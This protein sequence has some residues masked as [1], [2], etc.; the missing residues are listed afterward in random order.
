MSDAVSDARA[1]ITLSPELTN[2]LRERLTALGDD[3][4]ILGHRDSE[5]TGHA[6]ILEEDI[7][8]ANVAQDEI[9]HAVLWYGLVEQLGGPDP[10]RL[11]FFRSEGEFRSAPFVDRPRGDWA[12]TMARQFLFDAHEAELLPRLERSAFEPMAEV[13]A[14][15]R[16]EELFHLRHSA[17]WL[18][19]LAHGT[20]ES[21]RRLEAALD[22]LLP[23]LPGLLEPLPGDAA[24]AAAGIYPDPAELEAAVRSRIA[25]ALQKLDLDLPGA[26]RAAP[27]S[28][29][30][31]AA[32]S[33]R[34][35]GV[36]A[37]LLEE[38]QAVARSDPEAESW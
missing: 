37:E 30:P 11:A 38:M 29:Q 33:Q 19:R 23:L 31:G 8:I 1:S 6:P 2:A 26:S 18:E 24:L 15:V 21:R 25:A 5:W 10:D 13:A 36:L 28:G 22:E 4:L 27:S 17:L 20:D 32:R 35:D 12:F 14:K 34:D 9:G 16:R 3:E 7:A